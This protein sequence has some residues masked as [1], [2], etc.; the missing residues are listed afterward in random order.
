MT[1][2]SIGMG[3][4][5]I[6]LVFT[7]LCLAIFALLTYASAHADKSLAD[8]SARMTKS[9]YAADTL[10]EQILAEVLASED[11]P[12]EYLG[13]DIY[14]EWDWMAG[15]ERVIFSCPVTDTQEL[16]VEAVISI[17]SYDVLVW[18]VRN[19]TEDTWEPES[20]LPVW[21]GF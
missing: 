7:V 15:V 13:V 9:Y 19:I 10:A 6:I 14:N 12:D 3:S 8:A 18:K 16:Y 4:A 21:E 11:V 2:N 1:K 20:G 17:D 5:S